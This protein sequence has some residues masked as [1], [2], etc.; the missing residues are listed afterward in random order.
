MKPAVALLLALL[1]PVAA[2]AQQPPAPASTLRE[3]SLEQLGG[4][5]VT[6]VSKLPAEVWRSAAAIAVLTQD[7]IRRA[8]VTTLPELLRLIPGVQVARLD[9]DHWA[10]GI[11]GLTSSFSKAL[12]VLIDGRS[13]YTPLFGGVYWQV[14]DTLLEDIDRIEVIR[15]PGGTIWGTNAVNGVIN[16]I[17]KNSRET[18]GALVSV[19][20]GNV[21]QGRVGV[22]YG[23]SNGRGLS[24]RVYGTGSRRAAEH[25]TDGH[26][27]DD[28]S[29]A[30]GGFRI[31][32][33]RRAGETFRIQGDGYKGRTGERVA[34]GSFAPPAALLI[35]GSDDVAGGNVL[36]HWERELAGG[37][38][39][40]LQAYYD[41]TI[42]HAVHFE[43]TRDTFDVD[44]LHRA[45]LGPRHQL[46][47]GAGARNSASNVTELFPTL[48]VTPEDRAHRFA[49]IFAQDEIAVMA[50]RLWLTLGSKFEHNSY[51]GW[52]VQ[53]SARLL[54]R[55][56]S[57]ETVWAAVT[58]SAR[59]PS[60]IETDLMLTAFGIPNPLAYIL[61]AGSKDFDAETLVGVEAGYRRLLASQLYLDVTAFHNNYDGL[62]GFSPF[63]VTIEPAPIPHLQ[64]KT[65]YQNAIDGTSD[66]IEISPD[67]RPSSWLRLKGAYSLL[68]IDMENRPGNTDAQ[69]VALYEESIPRHQGSVQAALTLPG[70][71]EV[72]YTQR[73]MGRLV[74]HDIPHY[75]TADA[76]LGWQIGRGVTVAVAGQNLF[77]PNHVEFFRDEF[78]AVGIRRSVYASMTWRR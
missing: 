74:T 62:A 35:E 32:A 1:L 23:G 67:W 65:S 8:G 22:R 50:D 61:L 27:F 75:V 77:A 33:T 24:Y 46:A 41:R 14:Q 17:T 53:P 73:F 45:P 42:R 9:S 6:T 57:R 30:Q 2:G 26:P 11:R 39:F 55:P 38:G 4:L 15:G 13:V 63:A 37:A 7:D 76:R 40:R 28:W 68:T 49:S 31:D 52:E 54:W 43:E 36:A 20:G 56:S 10:L 72:D 16:I 18:A 47:W 44:F 25:H 48:T 66:G 29:I 78:A 70:A 21:D 58:R 69:N 59:I 60:R 3:L 12:L 71:V 19:G 34:V 64:F 51:S 5:E